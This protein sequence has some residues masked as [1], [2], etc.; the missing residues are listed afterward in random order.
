MLLKEDKDFINRLE[1]L[2]GSQEVEISRLKEM[3]SQFKDELKG[4]DKKI[5][6]LTS[7]RA[8]LAEQ[9]QTREV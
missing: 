2:E 9:V 3:V 1:V 8:D 4:R 6:A 7:E 5:E